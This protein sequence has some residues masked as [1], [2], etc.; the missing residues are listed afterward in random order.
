[1]LPA[2]QRLRADRDIQRV[3]KRG[4][5]RRGRFVTIVAA[6][7]DRTGHRFGYVV[8]KKVSN[9]AVERNLV[10][11]RLRAATPHVKWPTSNADVL[12][13]AAPAARNKS[14]ADLLADLLAAMSS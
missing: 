14:S 10:K 2:A 5:R 9:S 13:I 12:I 8:G 7:N 3:L 11:R 6:P 4:R 1:M